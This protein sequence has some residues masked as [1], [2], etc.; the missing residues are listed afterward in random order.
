MKPKLIVHQLPEFDPKLF[1]NCRVITATQTREQLDNALTSVDGELLIMDLDNDDAI[2]TMIRALEIRPALSIIGVTGSGDLERAIEAQ[3]SGCAQIARKPIDVDDLEAA[4]GRAR[5][6]LPDNSARSQCISVIGPTGGSGATTLACHLAVE[7]ANAPG[8]TAALIDLDFDFGGVARAF[9]LH[10]KFTIG[11][12][13]KTTDIDETLL[14]K[15]LAGTENGPDILAR[16]STIGDAHAVTSDTVREVISLC[17]SM[18]T[19]VVVDLPRK[20]DEIT[21][22]GIEMAD[23]LLLV[24]QLT[25]PSVD[26]A[27]RLLEI[28]EREGIDRERFNL[29]INRYRKNV[30]SC[31]VE[32]VEKQLGLEAI[33]TIPSDY[34]SVNRALDAGVL[35]APKHVVRTSIADLA[36]K[37]LGHK[38]NQPSKGWFGKLGFARGV[39]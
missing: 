35:L 18:Y 2:A 10:P 29:V 22:V 7:L 9:D 36:H 37:L 16:P 31:T 26:N 30:H 19:T 15:C 24:V 23:H 28:L 14:N 25:V 20:L 17:Q 27:V 3:R 34:S 32:M 1:P 11:D 21:G 12:L 8:S 38:P 39:S 33:G 6:V 4:I 5:H 13:A